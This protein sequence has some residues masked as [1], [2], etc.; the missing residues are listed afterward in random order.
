MRGRTSIIL[1]LRGASRGFPFR[2]DYVVII[3]DKDWAL[4]TAGGPELP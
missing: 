3:A 4:I 2:E 1:L